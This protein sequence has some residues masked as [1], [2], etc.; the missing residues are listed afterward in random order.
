MNSSKII[1]WVI[2]VIV[3]SLLIAIIWLGITQKKSSLEEEAFNNSFISSS[4][5]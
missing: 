2:P 1:G 4:A 3:A 5:E